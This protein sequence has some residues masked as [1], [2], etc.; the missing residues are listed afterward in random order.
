VD[1]HFDGSQASAQIGDKVGNASFLIGVDHLE[2]TSQPM[3][4]A[5]A[6]RS[7]GA[8]RPGDIAVTGA[9]P[10]TDQKGQAGV[11][12]G[13]SGEGVVKLVQDQFK[14]KL[15]YDLTP[16]LQAGFSLG[17]WNRRYQ[18][19]NDTFLQDMAGQS[20]YRG[21]VS[22]DGNHY[23]INPAAFAESRGQS[24][25]ALYGLS[26]K[27]RHE[28]GWNYSAY[29]SYFD[30]LAD[31]QRTGLAGGPNNGAGTIGSS[32][33]SG[34]KTLDVRAQYT[35][36]SNAAG[37]HTVTLGYH[38]DQYELRN[39]V[40]NTDHW[41]SGGAATLNNA[42]AGATLTQ[43]LYAQDA[44]KIADRWMLT[45]GLRYEAW[46]AFKGARTKDDSTLH[47]DTRTNA[48]ISPKAS[49]AYEASDALTLRA[50]IGQA[51]R[52]PTVSELFQGEI[53]NNLLVNNDPNLKPE[54]A[55]SKELAAEWYTEQGYMRLA[56]FQDDIRDALYS[57]TD[58]TVFPNITNIQN[59]DKVRNRG[60]ELSYQAENVWVNG[61][62]INAGAGYTH[63]K[64]LENSRYP[65]TAGNYFPRIPRWR[66][67]AAATY[68]FNPKTALTVAGRYS[69]RQYNTAENNDIN[70][71]T[72]GGTSSFFVLDTKLRYQFSDRIEASIGID[73]LFNKQAFVF[74]P[75]PGRT[76]FGELKIRL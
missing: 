2:N 3:L 39:K 38:Y 5:T 58:T 29:F 6:Q 66:L 72:Y 8:S 17:Y 57:Q 27:T 62:D 24:E 26:L 49:L 30:I 53:K 61:L 19:S 9:Q 15:A 76:L 50:S 43:A 13:T 36:M 73:N 46:K 12:L 67:N 54:N 40:F 25:S 37:S 44:W 69:G 51:Y 32:E 68:H 59:I 42:F 7:T 48:H 10:Y 70:P 16:T 18:S 64:I 20:V 34:W 56:V 22:I 74:H 71:N 35:P 60:V 1:K 14:F 28:R 75:Y 41:K 4:F 45:T 33:G 63:S 47:Y 23:D 52:F 55:L 21:G 31:S 65:E 11:V